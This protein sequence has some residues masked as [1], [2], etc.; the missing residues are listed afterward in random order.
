MIKTAIQARKWHRM[1]L[2]IDNGGQDGQGSTAPMSIDAQ[3]LYRAFER[4][5]DGRK[6]RGKRYPLALMLTLLLLGKL[7]G[8]TTLAGIV[9][10]VNER[11]QTLQRQLN[12]PKRFP[13]NSTYSEALAQCDGQAIAN[14]IALVLVNARAQEVCGEEPSRLLAYQLGEQY[15]IHTAMDGK[16]LRGTLQH[17]KETQPPVHL[18]SLYECERGIVLAQEALKSKENEITAAGALLRPALVKGRII[19]ADAMH[20]AR[21]RSGTVVVSGIVDIVYFS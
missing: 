1:N 12:W 9:D 20:C 4:V 19:S 13:V 11:K 2:S 16:T 6:A 18:L 14:V 8:E 3:S 7:A 15:L 5:T 21:S 10:W 17:D